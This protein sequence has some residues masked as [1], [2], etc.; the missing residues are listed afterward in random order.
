LDLETLERDFK[1][2]IK[3]KKEI[4]AL[5]TNAPLDREKVDDA[6]SQLKNHMQSTSEYLDRIPFAFGLEFYDQ[7]HLI[8]SEADN[9]FRNRK[10]WVDKLLSKL[11]NAPPL[12]LQIYAC[13]AT[14]S[15]KALEKANA[16]LVLLIR[17]LKG[18]PYVIAPERPDT[19]TVCELQ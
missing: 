9:V 2:I 17:K 15:A 4:S 19:I 7:G 14:Q 3:Y 18:E 11:W 12:E 16:E 1:G 8:A 6:A 13:Q 5:I 10:T